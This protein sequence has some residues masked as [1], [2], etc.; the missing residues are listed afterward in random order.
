MANYIANG[1]WARVKPQTGIKKGAY[2]V[3]TK[4]N[5]GD[6]GDHYCVGFYAGS[7]THG[8]ETRHL[9]V[10]S[11]GNLFRHNGFRR[12]KRVSSRRGNWL[13]ANLA[14]IDRMKDERSVWH[15]VRAPWKELNK[16]SP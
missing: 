7:Y 5:D 3:A 2:V 6:P 9:V 1:C 11:C 13:V 4:Y 8:S 15:W 12:V 10:D 14:L 16:V